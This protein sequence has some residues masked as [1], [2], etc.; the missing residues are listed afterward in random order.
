MSVD[1]IV[2]R[3]KSLKDDIEVEQLTTNTVVE[4]LDDII[5]ELEDESPYNFSDESLDNFSMRDY[6]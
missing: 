3:I 6:S 4:R 2:S 1:E 5:I